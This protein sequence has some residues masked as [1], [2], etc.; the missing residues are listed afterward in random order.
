MIIRA[1][2]A[3][4][5]AL[6]AATSAL[7]QMPPQPQPPKLPF[8][9]GQGNE[10]ERA[11]CHPDVVKFCQDSIPDQFRILTCLQTNRQKISKAC[12]GVLASH[13]I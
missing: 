8:P 3:T 2:L 7:A 5:I 4:A 11:A 12:G 10:Q 6:S 9:T 13:G 1:I